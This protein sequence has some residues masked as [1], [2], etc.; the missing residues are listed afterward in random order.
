MIRQKNINENG[1]FA[2]SILLIALACLVFGVQ[3]GIHDNYGIMMNGL[4]GPTG[5][6]YKDISFCIGIGDLIYG[7]AQP[8]MG[9]LSIRTSQTFVLISGIVMMAAGLCLTPLCRSFVP[10]L[11][12]FGILL[13]LARPVWLSVFS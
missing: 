13:P 11:L 12:C 8:F 9:T 2:R 1:S 7:A 5:I 4:L 3:Q 10:L 6:S